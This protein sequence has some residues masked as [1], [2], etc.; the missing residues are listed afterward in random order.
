MSK[1]TMFNKIICSVFKHVFSKDI[2]NT[3]Q[4][5]NSSG[6]QKSCTCN[7]CGARYVAEFA[8]GIDFD[9]VDEKILSDYINECGWEI[10]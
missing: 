5:L 3:Y 1:N 7:R 2:E 6:I 10:K 9:N 4:S 8:F